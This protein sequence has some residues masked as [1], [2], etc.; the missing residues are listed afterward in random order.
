MERLVQEIN[1]I[2][3]A[4]GNKIM[5]IYQDESLFGVELKKDESP[6]TIAD[7]SA[8]KIICEGLMKVTPDIPIISEE[9]KLMDYETR[10]S[11]KKCWVVDP[12]D[13]TKEFIKRNGEFTV[14][15]ALLEN[16]IP[17]LGVVYVPA[18]EELYYGVKS[19]GAFKS[20]KGAEAVKIVNKPF[21]L[22]DEGLK[23]VCSRSHLNE[24]TQT[25]I[26]QLN[27]PEKVA[28]GSSLKFLVLAT[29]EAH[30]YPRIAPTMEWDTCA[31]QVV[32][33]QAGGKVVK[34]E[35]ESQV[36]DYNKENLLNPYFVAYGPVSDHLN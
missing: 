7:T 17:V 8:N 16:N 14:N 35:D 30:I 27:K 9:N 18:K 34:F 13:G 11:F 28:K 25:F 32:L 6:L 15:I 24:E 2:A 31:A 5:E 29:G 36:L 23:V 22:N 26:D 4:A 20:I 3:I 21:G 10:K 1:K 12:L 19:L 33:E